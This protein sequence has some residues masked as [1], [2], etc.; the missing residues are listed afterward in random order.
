MKYWDSFATVATGR[1]VNTMT[2]E[3]AYDKQYPKRA[4]SANVYNH[5]K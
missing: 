3:S 4:K 5:A 1:A 2:N